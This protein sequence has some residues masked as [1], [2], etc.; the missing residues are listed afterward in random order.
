MEIPQF[1]T[2]GR[3]DARL[4]DQAA[5]RMG[6]SRLGFREEL[7]VTHRVSGEGAIELR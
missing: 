4:F 6:M 7:S 5:G 3:F 1:Q 2:D